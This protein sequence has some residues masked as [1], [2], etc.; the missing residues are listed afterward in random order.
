MFCDGPW[1]ILFFVYEYPPNQVRWCAAEK[2]LWNNYRL[3][4]D[5]PCNRFLRTGERKLVR[6][7]IGPPAKRHSNGVLLAARWWLTFICILGN[8]SQ[9][10]AKSAL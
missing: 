3:S 7:T 9:V 5:N 4:F 10:G 2:D 1:S 8:R 6:T